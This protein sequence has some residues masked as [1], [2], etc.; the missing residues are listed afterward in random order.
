MP[1]PHSIGT[2]AL[3][4]LFGGGG[5]LVSRPSLSPWAAILFLGGTLC[6]DLTMPQ[7]PTLFHLNLPCVFLFFF[8]TTNQKQKE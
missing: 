6:V 3:S 8:L 1:S 5:T 4:Q 7:R 2:G